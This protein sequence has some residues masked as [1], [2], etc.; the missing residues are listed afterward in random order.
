MKKIVGISIAFLALMLVFGMAGCK[1]EGSD[2]RSADAD[3]TS[4]VMGDRKY[5]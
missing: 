3:L 2:T 1:T 5:D 4:I